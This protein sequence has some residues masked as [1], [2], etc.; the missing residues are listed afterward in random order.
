MQQ[1]SEQENVRALV[2]HVR[3]SKH[4]DRDLLD[5]KSEEQAS[6]PKKV[7]LNKKQKMFPKLDDVPDNEAQQGFSEHVVDS[8][9]KQQRD[10]I[11]QEIA[12]Q[13]QFG[14]RDKNTL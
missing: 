14:V 5:S 6:S 4:R 11:K 10:T 2:E 3:A 12:K 8:A 9:I 13:M 1:L 7:E